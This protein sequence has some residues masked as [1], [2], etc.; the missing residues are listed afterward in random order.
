MNALAEPP[1]PKAEP[2]EKELITGLQHTVS[3]SRLTLFCS[4][5]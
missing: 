2:S 1:T 3:A 5:D 4:A